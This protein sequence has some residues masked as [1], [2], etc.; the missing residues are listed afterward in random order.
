MPTAK[1]HFGSSVLRTAPHLEKLWK[2]VSAYRYLRDAFLSSQT[3]ESVQFHF[4][5]NNSVGIN[6]LTCMKGQLNVDVIKIILNYSVCVTNRVSVSS[7][8]EGS[9]MS[10]PIGCTSTVLLL[11]IVDIFSKL[12]NPWIDQSKRFN[13]THIVIGPCGH[14][15]K[16]VCR[17]KTC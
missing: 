1:R 10:D 2:Q 6:A 9:R 3:S 4:F 7:L 16:I 12:Q 5:S 13:N 14:V 17:S 8:Q 11:G 15:S